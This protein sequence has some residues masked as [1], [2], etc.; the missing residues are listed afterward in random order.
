VAGP[1]HRGAQEHLEHLEPEQCK[2]IGEQKLRKAAAAGLDPNEGEIIVRRIDVM[3]IAPDAVAP[4]HWAAGDC[5][6]GQP[7]SS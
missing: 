2:A 5:V 1:L 6:T 3:L 7:L 4:Y